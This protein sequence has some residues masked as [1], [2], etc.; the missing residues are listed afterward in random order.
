MPKSRSDR[1]LIHRLNGQLLEVLGEHMD[2]ILG[3]EAWKPKEWIINVI[4]LNRSTEDV[5]TARLETS[6]TLYE[7]VLFDTREPFDENKVGAFDLP[8]PLD[9]SFSGYCIQ[10]GNVV[11][12]DNLDDIRDPHPLYA[13]Y[14]KFEF[15]AV[16]PQT[17]PTAEYVFPLFARIGLIQSLLGVLNMEFFGNESP[18]RFEPRQLHGGQERSLAA[19]LGDLSQPQGPDPQGAEVKRDPLEISEPIMKLLSAHSPFLRVASLTEV[20]RITTQGDSFFETLLDLHRQV[21]KERK[22]IFEKELAMRMTSLHMRRDSSK[23]TKFQNVAVGTPAV[24]TPAVG[25]PTPESVEGGSKAKSKER[26]KLA[27]KDR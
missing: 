26:A 10:T 13:Y 7:G 18:F 9:R 25:T 17:R 15:V 4:L 11:W 23:D 22:N 19:R 20:S 3:R 6:A 12:V 21:L 5:Y 27:K 8:V 16:Q 1:E 2:L 14:R 24:G